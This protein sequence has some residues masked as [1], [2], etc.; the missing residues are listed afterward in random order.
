MKPRA[1]LPLKRNPR[2]QDGRALD[3]ALALVR[4]GLA[5]G[6]ASAAPRSTHGASTNRTTIARAFRICPPKRHRLPARPLW[7]AVWHRHFLTQSLTF[8]DFR[9]E[10]KCFLVGVA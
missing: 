5:P 2:A 10:S 9:A 1:W 7:A 4:N 8:L 6:T 3:T